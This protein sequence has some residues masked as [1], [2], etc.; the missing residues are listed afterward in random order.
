MYAFHAKRQVLCPPY[1]PYVRD[2]HRAARGG[3]LWQGLANPQ[4]KSVLLAT[5]Q[6][7]RAAKERCLPKKGYTQPALLGDVRERAPCTY[8]RP[9]AQT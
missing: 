6:G 4:T 8:A 3:G 1:D 9:G 7:G 2:R 5:F